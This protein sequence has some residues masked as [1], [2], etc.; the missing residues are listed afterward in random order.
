MV[1]RIVTA[2]RNGKSCVVSDGPVANTHDFAAM[3]GFRTTLA[4]MTRDVPRFPDDGGAGDPVARV[5]TMLPGP[6]GSCLIVVTF[7]PDSVMMSPAF[8]GAAAAAEQAEFL[9]GLA[10]T[11]DPDG[12]GMH[13]TATLDYDVIVEGELWLELDDG[14]VRHLKAGDV[15]IQ[16]GTRHAWRNRTDKPTTMISFMVGGHRDAA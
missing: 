14:D 12:S 10:D 13:I 3:P 4:W 8:D 11:F 6:G 7:P 2:E 1:R 5:D 9:P 16:N 15:V